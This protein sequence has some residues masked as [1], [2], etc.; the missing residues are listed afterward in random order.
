[1]RK[2]KIIF[3]SALLDKIAESKKMGEGE[4]LN[5]LKYLAYLTPKEQVL[6]AQLI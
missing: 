4:K 5:I 2:S 1:M 6:L 3:D